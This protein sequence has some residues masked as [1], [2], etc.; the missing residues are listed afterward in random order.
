MLPEPCINNDAPFLDPHS[1]HCCLAAHTVPVP[2]YTSM[3]AAVTGGSPAGE[4]TLNQGDRAALFLGPVPDDKLPADAPGK[5][6]QGE[7]S[8]GQVGGLAG[9]CF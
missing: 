1:R 2:V 7:L 4:L 9:C 8:L 5:V 6:L 3:H